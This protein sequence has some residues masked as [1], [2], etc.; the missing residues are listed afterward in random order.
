MYS[1]TCLSAQKYIFALLVSLAL[2]FP[3]CSTYKLQY[4]CLFFFAESTISEHS[5]SDD[6]IKFCIPEIYQRVT[7]SNIGVSIISLHDTPRLHTLKRVIRIFFIRRTYNE[8]SKLTLGFIHQNPIKNRKFL[9]LYSHNNNKVQ[10]NPTSFCLMPRKWLKFSSNQSSVKLDLKKIDLK[11]EMW[12]V[13]ALRLEWCYDTGNDKNVTI[14]R[15]SM[16]LI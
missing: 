4:I 7:T 11:V 6:M 12:P 8:N 1:I 10:K 2:D 14:I 13:N 3:K 5:V 16:Q 15:L 9:L